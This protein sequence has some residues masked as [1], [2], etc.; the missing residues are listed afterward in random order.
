[1]RFLLA[2]ERASDELHVRSA[3]THDTGRVNDRRSRVTLTAS[4]LQLTVMQFQRVRARCV[5]EVEDS[6]RV[7]HDATTRFARNG[8]RPL[9]KFNTVGDKLA[10]DFQ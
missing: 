3:R 9:Q 6:F 10:S 2:R 7:R 1:M 8:R 4:I 5:E